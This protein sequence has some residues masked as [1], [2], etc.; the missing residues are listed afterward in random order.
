[1]DEVSGQP[2][3]LHDLGIP[4]ARP[5]L[6]FGNP[7][8]RIAPLNG[9]LTVGVFPVGGF[10]DLQMVAGIDEVACQAVE[11]H[12]FRITGAGTQKAFG[13]PPK[14][15]AALDLVKDPSVRQRSGGIRRG[16]P[17]RVRCGGGGGGS[18][19]TGGRG[20]RVARFGCCG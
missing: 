8:Q 15:I 18:A 16:F 9:V 6:G 14:G 7:P 20:G 2:V 12:D 19:P 13:Y 1:M 17:F 4:Q 5:Q 11:R 10:G 3:E